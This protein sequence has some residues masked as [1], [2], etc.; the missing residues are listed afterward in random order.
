MNNISSNKSSSAASSDTTAN[1]KTL[2]QPTEI[3]LLIFDMGKVFVYF[4]WGR[5]YDAF[6]EVTKRDLESVKTA[7]AAVYFPYERGDITTQDV[8][9]HLNKK[10]ESSL[11]HAEFSALWTSTLDEDKEMTQLLQTLRKT[12]LP[13]YLLSNIN[14][15][16]FGH[17]QDNFN[18]SQHFDELVLSYKV[19]HIKPALEIYHEVLNRSKMPAQNCLFIDDMYENIEAAKAVGINGIHFN[20]IQDLKNKLTDYGI[21]V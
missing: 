14:E 3:K 4:D 8:I 19:G 5:T 6:V 11:T 13:M 12:G 10:L 18:V 21:K 9:N 7:F 15:V 16:S 1:E 20:G 2:K 17:L